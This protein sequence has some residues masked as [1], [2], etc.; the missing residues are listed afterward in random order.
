MA[1]RFE[2]PKKEPT[3]NR[4]EWLQK[5]TPEDIAEEGFRD[6]PHGVKHEMYALASVLIEQYHCK[7]KEILRENPE[8]VLETLREFSSIEDSLVTGALT[9]DGGEIGFDEN[10]LSQVSEDS[11]GDSLRG[12]NFFPMIYTQTFDKA[13]VAERSEFD[14][15]TAAVYRRLGDLFYHTQSRMV[16]SSGQNGSRRRAQSVEGFIKS[17]VATAATESWHILVTLTQE[18]QKHFNQEL[19]PEV[20]DALTADI[21]KILNQVASLH[22][23]DFD[24]FRK[25][26]VEEGQPDLSQVAWNKIIEFS[27]TPPEVHLSLKKEYQNFSH[28]EEVER[29]EC[30]QGCPGRDAVVQNQ[31][32]K[33]VNIIGDVF[34]FYKELAK[35]VLLPHQRLLVEK[36]DV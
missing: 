28:H 24:H 19:T 4:I 12:E 17:G 26:S 3:R 35:R 13:F 31:S 36:Y 5:A 20:T 32:G 27:G 8:E 29:R 30:T 25:L 9:V 2:G 15:Q 14:T 10:R 34:D 21:K 6:L 33:K 7:V 23:A 16:F 1:G 18:Y 22:I 11:L